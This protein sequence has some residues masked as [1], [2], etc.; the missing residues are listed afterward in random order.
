[1]SN[2]TIYLKGPFGTGI[3]Y[4]GRTPF[5]S[6]LKLG[7]ACLIL[8]VA[9]ISLYKYKKKIDIDEEIRKDKAV[10]Q[11]KIDFDNVHTENNRQKKNTRGEIKKDVLLRQTRE[12][13]SNCQTESGVSQLS[14]HSWIE[15]FHSEYVM[16]DYSTIPILADVLA[17]SPDGYQDAMMLHLLSAFGGICFSKV[18]AEFLDKKFHSPSLLTIIEG[19]SGSGKGN[20]NTVYK[21]LFHRILESD[22]NKL[23]LEGCKQIIQTAGINVSASKFMDILAF[24]QGVHIYAM[25]TEL[26]KVYEAFSRKGGLEFSYLRNAFDN[27][28]VYQNNNGRSST[29]GSFPVYFNCTFTGTPNAVD[30]LIN[31]KEVEGGTARRFVSP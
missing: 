20:F 15:K 27:D 7:S 1:M 10:T 26:V 16:P 4:K 24:N 9:G 5:L 17:A 21:V 25:E 22:R 28:E 14:L 29:R 23:K 11:N 18:R 30:S 19:A 8:G 31:E 3:R 2:E 13:S 12:Y 6:M